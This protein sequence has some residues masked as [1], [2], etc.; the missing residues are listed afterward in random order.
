M[1]SRAG[2]LVHRHQNPKSFGIS[3]FAVLSPDLALYSSKATEK[4]PK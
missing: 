4:S 1:A 3:S 2:A